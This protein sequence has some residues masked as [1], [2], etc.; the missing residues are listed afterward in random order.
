MIRIILGIRILI[1]LVIGINNINGI[2]IKIGI[3]I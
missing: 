2:R 1:E 3:R